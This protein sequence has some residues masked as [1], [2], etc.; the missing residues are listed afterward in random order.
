[1]N[2]CCICGTIKNVGPYINKV[3]ETIEKIGSYFDNY[4]IILYYDKSDDDTLQKLKAYQVKNNKRYK[5][6]REA[7]K[8]RDQTN[9]KNQNKRKEKTKIQPHDFCKFN[10]IHSCNIL[11]I[12]GYT[13]LYCK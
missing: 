2:C 5:N 13:G 11:V 3:F 10:R 6:T 12:S 4:V 9:S 1:M 8:T 7:C